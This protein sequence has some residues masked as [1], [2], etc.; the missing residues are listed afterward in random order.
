[1]TPAK[2]TMIAVPDLAK[3]WG[4]SRGFLW[5]RCKK[6]QMPASKIGDRWFVPM[7]YVEQQEKNSHNTELDLGKRQFGNG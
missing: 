6:E 2:I 4:C 3:R 7:W 1:M 5:N